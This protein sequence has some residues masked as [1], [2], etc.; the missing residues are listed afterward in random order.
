MTGRGSN[1]FAGRALGPDPLDDPLVTGWDAVIGRDSGA[2][3][4]ADADDVML[5]RRFLA[6]D[7]VPMPAPG[8]FTDLEQ[9]LATLSPSQGAPRQSRRPSRFALVQTAPPAATALRPIPQ[10]RRW[11]PMYSALATLAVMLVV[12]LLVL[13][14]AVPGPSEP[15]P[16]PAAVIAKP[17]IEPFAEFEFSPP[18]WGMPD[19]TDWTHMETSLLS[20]APATS[21]TTDWPKYVAIDGP[22]TFTVLS[23]ELAITPAGPAFFYP[24]HRFGQPP[25]EVEAGE[26]VSMGPNDTIV[27]SSI[28]TATGSNPGSVPALVLNSALG[29]RDKMLPGSSV[30]PKDVSFIAHEY[31]KAFIPNLPTTGATVTLQRLQLAPFDTFVFEP[32]KDWMYLALLDRSQSD[33]LRIDD[34][35]IEGLLPNPG[36]QGIYGGVQL[37][38]Y[39]PGPRT[40]F[41]L[42]DKTVSIYFL[43]IEPFPDG[44]VPPA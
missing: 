25:V 16:I 12:S 38:P 39:K 24:A 42:G 2:Q 23:G 19:A 20:I 35:A 5:I 18:M 11:T 32:G 33:G 37:R 40:I 3:N 28:D 31:D 6:L 9:T 41:N 1:T 30:L 14:Q 44:G 34:G 36:A 13:Y 22:L 29:I 17:T 43:V 10:P 15:P 21:F 27:Y 4:N 8:F 26:E 7:T